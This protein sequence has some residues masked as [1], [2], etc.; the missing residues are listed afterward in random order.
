MNKAKTTLKIAIPVA[1]GR[2]CLHFGHCGRFAVLTLDTTDLA[3][4][5]KDEARATEQ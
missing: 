4:G 1:E 3:A 5:C 2:L